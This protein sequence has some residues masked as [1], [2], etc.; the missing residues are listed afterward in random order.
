MS[1][2]PVN[3]ASASGTVE[4]QTGAISK[5]G[6][7]KLIKK[8]IS[9]RDQKCELMD[10]A[11]THKRFTFETDLALD[12][13][14]FLLNIFDYIRVVNFEIDQFM[15]D[16]FWQSLTEGGCV[17]MDTT[18][19]EWLGYDHEEERYRKA[20][21][22]KL[23]KSN[24]IDF[25]QIKHNDPDFDQYPEFVAE[26]AQLSA[27]ALKSQKWIIIDS[28]DFKRVVFS[29]RTKRSSDI[30]NYYLSLE[31]LMAMYTEYTHHYQLRIERRRAELEK[32]SLTDMMENLKIEQ[33]KEREERK[34]EREEHLRER[35][36][37]ERRYNNLMK[38]GDQLLGHA[39]QAEEDRLV[40]MKDLNEVRKVAAPHPEERKNVHRMAVVRMSPRYKWSD[41]DPMYYPDVDAIAIRTQIKYFGGRVSQIKRAGN[42]TNKDAEVIVSF[43]SPNPISLFNR[44]KH[45]KEEMFTF[46]GST[47]IRYEPSTE[48]DLIDAVNE[49]HQDRMTYPNDE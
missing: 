1:T 41:G 40:M 29:L 47:G 4:C 8:A 34:K 39:E 7:K 12:E 9:A 19:L 13:D 27:A 45:T 14:S 16:K 17:F 20:A 37:A 24:Q 5:K 38:R 25:K 23:L 28:Q 42:G 31:R 43:D 48:Q 35:E 11:S 18:V 44:I 6:I 46:V 36:A 3:T 30:V 22:L 10:V 21:F 32:K 26:A 2:Y 49:L 33:A 15:L